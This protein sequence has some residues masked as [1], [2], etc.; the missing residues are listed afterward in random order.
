M[1]EQDCL[2]VVPRWMN[3]LPLQ[4]QSVML[5]ASRGPD[6]IAKHHPCKNVVRAYRGTVLLAA[7]YGRPLRWGEKA[8]TFMSLDRIA[9]SELWDEDVKAYFDSVD[10]LPHHRPQAPELGHARRVADLLCEGL[11]RHAPTD[12]ERGNDG[13]APIGLG[14]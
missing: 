2:S 7:R 10:Q 13:R 6:G 11:R 8:D 4:Q 14:P 12:G 5:L 9:R 3:T 1:S